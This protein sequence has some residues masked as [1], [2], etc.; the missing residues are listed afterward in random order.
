MLNHHVLISTILVGCSFVTTTDAFTIIGSSSSRNNIVAPLGVK[1]VKR[2]SLGSIAED[3]MISTPKKLKNKSS[4]RKT[5]SKR[6]P[7]A[8]DT[9]SSDLTSWAASKKE[10][11]ASTT[12]PA[13]A[14][15]DDNDD[16]VAG[17]ESFSSMEDDDEEISSSRSKNLITNKATEKLLKKFEEVLKQ[18]NNLDD[19]LGVVKAMIELSPKPTTS[20]KSLSVTGKTPINYRLAWVGGDDAICHLGTGLH[21]VPLA[22]LQ[23]VFLRLQGRSDLEM[24]EVISVLGPFPNVRNT[25]YGKCQVSKAESGIKAA[26]AGNNNTVSPW[27]IE[28]QSM[29]DGTGKEILPGNDKRIVNLNIHFADSSAIIAV[30]PPKEDGRDVDPLESNGAN[31]LLFVRDDEMDEKLEALRVL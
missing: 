10:G 24:Y 11:A 4:S 12:T 21:K 17:F 15:V 30:V 22:R 13:A 1:K 27:S 18:N 7:V 16:D 2:Q 26:A 31:V 6:R 23:E 28:W 20:I 8:G 5:N 14:T 29:I 25:L 9:I 19:I 3:G